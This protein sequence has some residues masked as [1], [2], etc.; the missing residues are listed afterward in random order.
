MKQLIVNAD[1]FGLTSGVNRAIIEC[2]QRGIVSSTTLMATGA[3]L[4][5]AIELAQQNPRL[6][7][8]CHIVLVD[9]EPVLP[10][11]QVRS[12]LAPGTNRFHHSLGPLLAALA[13]GG[14]QPAEV[15]A[16]A[17]AQIARLQ[18][19]GVT[20]SHVDAHKHTH[21]FPAILRP[22]LRAAAACGL[23]RVRNPFEPA[24][25]V[26]WGEALSSRMLC[27]RKLE[28]TL[29]RRIFRP[30]WLSLVHNQSFAT[31]CGSLG[32]ISTGALT[33]DTLTALLHR[34]PDGLWELCCHPGYH[35]AALTQI[36]TRLRQS[37]EIERQALLSLSP[38]TLRSQFQTELISFHQLSLAWHENPG[39]IPHGTTV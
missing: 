14:L 10:A 8:G 20:L 1:D 2:H 26:G 16:E 18:A 34:M 28:T 24:D 39:E 22:L 31:P 27:E 9:G 19:R 36:R 33:S 3:A 38:T 11:A 37:R 6:S 25:T 5:E 21:M 12:L 4:D 13:R 15:E 17:T 7:V 23:Q 35:D 29:L 30:H 32:I